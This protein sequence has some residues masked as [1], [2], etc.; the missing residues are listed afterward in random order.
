MKKRLSFLKF[1]V[2]IVLLGFFSASSFA[3]IQASL[4]ED[5]PVI[6]IIKPETPQPIPIINV[7]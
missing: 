1:T 7:P 3:G 6:I 4:T 5:P 2:I